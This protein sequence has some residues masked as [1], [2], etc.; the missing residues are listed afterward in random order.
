[1]SSY[2]VEQAND[3]V[4]LDFQTHPA[5]YKHWQLGITPPYATLSLS[6]AE[7]GG[8]FPGYRLKRNSY[9][10][11]VDIELSDAVMRLRFEHPEVRAVVITSALADSFCAG[12]NIQMLGQASHEHKVNFCKF[13]NET[14]NAIEDASAHSGQ[15]YMA[16]INGTAAGG[17]FELALATDYLLLVDDGNTAVS[18]PEV[19]LLAVLPGTGGLTRLVDK[20]K[21]RR[22]IADVFC[23]LEEGMRSSRALKNKLVDETVPRSRFN[24][25]VAELAMELAGGSDRPTDRTGIPLTPLRRNNRSDGIDYEHLRVDYQSGLATIWLRGPQAPAPADAAGIEKE[26]ASFWP[27]ALLRELDDA[28]L[29]LRFNEPSLGTLVFKSVGDLDRALGYDALLIEHNDDWLVRE[30]NLYATRVFKR[31]DL[32]ARSLFAL[33]EP[34]SCF[35]GWLSEILFAVD[36]SYIL[37]GTSDTSDGEEEDEPAGIVLSESNFGRHPMVNGLSRL[38]TRFLGE[39]DTLSRVHTLAGVTLFAQPALKEGLV[40]FALDDIDWEDE[41]RLLL[42]ERSSFSPDALSGMEANLRFPGPET[43][44]SK[45]FARLSTW[46]NWIFQRPNAVGEKGALPLFGS[47]RRPDFDKN[48]V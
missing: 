46:Q 7:D 16:A 13:T 9:D 30:V 24:E 3:V 20:R 10:I 17:G 26:G 12:A 42:E 34:G 28:L 5:R 27:L 39:P 44:E 22:D 1:M 31:L 33:I 19:S 35:A 23:T 29:H 11:G 36:R 40:T 41:I 37:E 15:R 47:G 32:T 21:I 45:I 48:R 18:L 38:R 2:V 43:M 8:V 4:A 14:R 6:V 25:R